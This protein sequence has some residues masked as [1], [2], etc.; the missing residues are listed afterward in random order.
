MLRLLGGVW[1]NGPLAC[2]YATAHALGKQQI[3]GLSPN[4]WNGKTAP[5][6]YRQMSH[7]CA[8]MQINGP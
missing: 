6:F 2:A 3:L 8:H 1:A 7:D 5:L 4:L